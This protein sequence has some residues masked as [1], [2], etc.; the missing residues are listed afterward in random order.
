MKIL[1]T[2]ILIALSIIIA[3]ASA[4]IIGSVVRP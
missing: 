1:K 2:T 3:T 4:A